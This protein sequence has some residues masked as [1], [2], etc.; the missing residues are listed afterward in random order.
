L[1]S[2]PENNAKY[3]ETLF[4]TNFHFLFNAI[5]L[6]AFASQDDSVIIE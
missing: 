2:A 6:P 5:F 3:H 1:K 4:E